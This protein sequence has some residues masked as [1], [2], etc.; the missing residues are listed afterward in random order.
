MCVC[1]GVGACVCMCLC[2]CVGVRMHA[3]AV[4]MC[5]CVYVCV[6][7]RRVTIP[8]GNTLCVAG[9]IYLVHT[10]SLISWLTA[11]IGMCLLCYFFLDYVLQQFPIITPIML[12]SCTYFAQIISYYTIPL[13]VCT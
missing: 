12:K 13:R 7:E 8:L 6:C 9:I 3:C 5:V 11:I 1:A 2:V 4:C 10:R